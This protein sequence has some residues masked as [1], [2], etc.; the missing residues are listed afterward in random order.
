MKSEKG[1]GLIMII[2]IVVVI[3][4]LIVT[5][6]IFINKNISKEKA[7]SIE[8]NMLKIQGACK[9]LKNDSIVKKNTDM[10]VGTKITDM[11]DDEIINN[12]KALNIIEEAQY[13]KFYCLNDDNLK[14]LDIEVENEEGSYYL[15]D[16]DD[17]IV[18]ITKGLNGKYK[19]SDIIQ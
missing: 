5:G 18:I 4:G 13:E 1:I 7:E 19:L 11:P 14:A 8:A 6:V 9:V 10:F 12:F 17:D 16:Y 2:L 3:I 15:V